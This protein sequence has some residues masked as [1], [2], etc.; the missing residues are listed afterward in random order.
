MSEEVRE[1]SPDALNDFFRFERQQNTD[2]R[3][4]I[5]EKVSDSPLNQEGKSQLSHD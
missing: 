5:D 1:V 4:G 2:L 3:G